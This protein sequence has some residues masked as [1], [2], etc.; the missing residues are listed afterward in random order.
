MKDTRT[1]GSTILTPS[2]VL[3]EV[4][5]VNGELVKEFDMI[6]N[7]NE[8]KMNWKKCSKEKYWARLLLVQIV[9]VNMVEGLVKLLIY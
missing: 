6:K 4:I 8:C 5:D 7:C 2:V 1:E 3:L 9:I